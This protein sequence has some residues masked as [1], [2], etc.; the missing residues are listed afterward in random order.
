MRLLHPDKLEENTYVLNFAW[1][2]TFIGMSASVT[3]RL[4]EHLEKKFPEELPNPAPAEMLN[5]MDQEVVEFL[6]S[7]YPAV[8]RSLRH[9]LEAL[10]DV[11]EPADEGERQDRDTPAS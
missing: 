3:R 7:S 1:L 9:I 8:A 10:R 5:R 11:E 6:C 2:P 4:G